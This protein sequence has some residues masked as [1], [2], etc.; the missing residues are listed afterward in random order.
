MSPK[1]KEGSILRSAR[2]RGAILARGL[3][4]TLLFLTAAAAS[5]EPPQAGAAAAHQGASTLDDRIPHGEISESQTPK[6]KLNLLQAN[7]DKSKKDATEL[8]ALARQLREELDKPNA[9]A[10]SLDVTNRLE[11]IEKL[12]KKIRD[13][14]KGY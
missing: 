10:L 9:N 13:E 1:I 3:L 5:A 14:M 2:R 7:F 12:A 6:Q 11:R 4:V 8:A